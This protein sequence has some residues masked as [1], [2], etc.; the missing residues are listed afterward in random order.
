M[1]ENGRS[2]A[3]KV[4]ELDNRDS[5]FYLALYWAQELAAQTEDA[6]LA[7]LFAEVADQ[8]SA[9]QDKIAEESHLETGKPVD[10]GGYY[11]PDPA[12]VAAVMRPSATFAAVLRRSKPDRRRSL[13]RP[14]RRRAARACARGRSR[15]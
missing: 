15:A 4:G 6:T 12:C 1:L 3:R 9:A 8:L 7:E 11:R 2:P 5:H 10:L 14:A 13:G